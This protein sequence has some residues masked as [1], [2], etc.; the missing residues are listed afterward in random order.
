MALPVLTSEESGK[1]TAYKHMPGKGKPRRDSLVVRLSGQPHT[2]L[3]P[4]PL[5]ET[6]VPGTHSE[7]TV[8]PQPSREETRQP[9]PTPV[10]P[11]HRP[12]IADAG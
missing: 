9:I 1:G 7:G 4:S 10:V 12:I 8:T 11:S 2:E 6:E 5:L 3:S